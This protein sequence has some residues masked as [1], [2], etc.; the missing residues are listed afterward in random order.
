MDR[1]I[2]GYLKRFVNEFDYDSKEKELNFEK[3]CFYS[4][5]KNELNY[6][7]SDDLEEISIGKNKG[8]DGI[9]LSIDGNIATNISEII[10]LKDNVRN[11]SV[12]IYFI[13]AKTSAKFED[14]EISNFCDTVIDFLNDKPEFP[15]TPRAKEY[16]N[17][18]LELLSLLSNIQSFN[19]KLFYC[20]PG[21]WHKENTGQTIVNQK[22]D[23]LNKIGVFKNDILDI[24]P[25]DNEK[26]RKY[27]DK[28]IQPLTTEFNF[29]NKVPFEE[30]EHVKES[31]LGIIP[32]SEYKKL[33]IDPDTDKL[34][35]LFY[36]N[37]R[38]F[39]GIDQEVNN[40]ID[41]TIK[42][43]KFAL[44]KLLNNGITVIAE[45]NKG[46]VNKF[47]LSNYQI[48]NGCQT[49]NV[50]YLNR[51]NEGIDALNI[52]LKLIITTDSYIRDS[53]IIS[54]NNQTQIKEEQLLALTSFQKGLEE[55]YKQM[56]DGIYYERRKSQ[57]SS[58][59][60]ITK[61]M[62]V[63]IRE[64]IK[65][66]VAMFLDEPHVVSGYFGKVYKDR[67]NEIFRAEHK[68]EPYYVS[69][70]TQYKFK[71]FLSTKK[72]LRIFNKARYHIFMLFRMITEP[73]SKPAPNNKKIVSYCE[74]ILNIL[75]DD[76][77]CFNN[78]NNSIKII[79]KS[80]I[81]Y[82][83]QKEIYKKSTTNTFIEEFEKKYK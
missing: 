44:F 64:Q 74:S 19:C 56:G 60:N 3:F 69:A 11:F 15:L 8:I 33:I 14:N 22:K 53:I 35:P 57:Y 6:L 79:E 72:D 36:D 24:I 48:V 18:Y 78:F 82:L 55:Y 30:I 12:T 37:V 39:L 41:Q 40:K 21:V 34:K 77:K 49:S 52:P 75:R 16:H 61:K 51:N 58:E 76:K 46:R 45:E 80:G 43:N 42:E 63:D 81:S 66:Y 83:D 23:I 73:Q 68:Y 54:S 47:L 2:E 38:D 5:L 25:I 70:L 26:L 20:S 10:D 28:A 1:I 71:Y 31:F 27:F 7:N 65:S 50:L 9:C 59:P 62:I 32:F 17:I 29:V 13:Q 4:V 67:N